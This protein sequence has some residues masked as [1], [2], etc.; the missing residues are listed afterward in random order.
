MVNLEKNLYVLYGQDSFYLKEEL[1]KIIKMERIENE[2]IEYFDSDETLL[3]DIIASAM[4]IPFLTEEK[5]VVL[6]N[7]RFLSTAKGQKEEDNQL[8]AFERYLKNPN[9]TTLFIILV[10]EP[11]LDKKKQVVKQLLDHAEV[12]ECIK[13]QN[14]DTYAKIKGILHANNFQ[15]DANALQQFISR[16]SYD[17]LTMMNE[18]EK[19]ML[20]SEGK[21]Q[22]TMDMVRQVV[23]RNLEENIFNLV[24]AM[25]AKDK[26]LMMSLYADLLELNV[27]PVWMIGVIVSKFQ[28]ILY[29]KE[30][31]SQ[32]KSF[33]E[34]MKYFS[35]SKGRVYYMTKN[36]RDTDDQALFVY[37]SKL[38]NLDYEIKSG[39]IDRFIGLEMFLYK[40]IG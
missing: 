13:E 17:S 20:F 15:I 33:E 40:M 34:I 3:E 22:I 21:T 5:A 6:Q 12:I 7:A 24:N 14:E 8:I 4:T 16:T 30:M 26:H 39:K 27:D 9:P 35:A 29:T 2:A 37:L 32:K 25:L 38:E 36:A 31:L 23:S 19:L 1:N 18:L 28:E 11:S 10:P